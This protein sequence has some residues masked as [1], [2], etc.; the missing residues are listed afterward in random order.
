M[1][2][3]VSILP[4]FSGIWD[5]LNLSSGHKFRVSPSLNNAF[6]PNPKVSSLCGQNFLSE[7]YVNVT[8]TR[9]RSEWIPALSPHYSPM[10][11]ILTFLMT[12][13]L[14]WAIL[15]IDSGPLSLFN[16]ATATIL[17][18][19]IGIAAGVNNESTSEAIF[20]AHWL[21]APFTTIYWALFSVIFMKNYFNK[22]FIKTKTTSSILPSYTP[23]Q[24]LPNPD[25]PASTTDSY[26][27]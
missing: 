19:G 22:K 24:Q 18:F 13:L 11:Y 15:R 2:I 5:G 9:H 14:P 3:V 12:T 6:K 23:R 16:G 26:F 27:F 4:A 20:K 1:C 10:I 8:C 25:G 7:T 17:M 21:G